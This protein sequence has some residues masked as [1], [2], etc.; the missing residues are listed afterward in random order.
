MA[1]NAVETLKEKPSI[2]G[3]IPLDIP[4]ESNSN[5][6]LFSFLT[7]ANKNVPP[8]EPIPKDTT[9]RARIVSLMD[10]SLSLVKPG[11]MESNYI[12]RAQ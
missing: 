8:A 9:N 7:P 12:A 11:S 2:K 1:K 10:D 3:E 6:F 4:I 5:P